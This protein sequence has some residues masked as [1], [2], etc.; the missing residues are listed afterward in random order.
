[1]GPTEVVLW[2]PCPP[3]IPAVFHRGLLGNA[4]SGKELLGQTAP[5]KIAGFPRRCRPHE[6]L[7]RG[8]AQQEGGTVIERPRWLA[9]RLM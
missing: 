1:M 4:R 9:G 2:D 7:G 6:Q 5:R 3:G 8:A